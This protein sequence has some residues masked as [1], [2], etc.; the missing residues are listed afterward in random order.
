MNPETFELSLEQQFNMRLFE[1]SA[2]ELSYEQA[3][4]L[5]VQ[6]SRLLMLKDNVIRSLLKQA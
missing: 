1:Q 2:Q 4:E 3:V 6:A 5:L